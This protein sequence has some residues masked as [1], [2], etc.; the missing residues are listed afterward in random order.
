VILK[1]HRNVSTENFARTKKCAWRIMFVAME[2]LLNI[3][4]AMYQY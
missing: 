2:R 4:G 1:E 3:K